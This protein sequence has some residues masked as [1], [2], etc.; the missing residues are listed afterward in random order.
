MVFLWSLPGLWEWFKTP[1]KL[2]G[3]ALVA[4]LA[5]SC[6][7]DYGTKNETI[8]QLNANNQV[9][10]IS[11][12]VNEMNVKTLEETLTKNHDMMTKTLEVQQLQEI[13]SVELA[14]FSNTLNEIN[15]QLAKVETLVDTTSSDIKQ[16]SDK[17]PLSKKT[18]AKLKTLDELTQNL[19]F[20]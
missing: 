1:I 15:N 12:T 8:A 9:L 11:N 14:V 4:Y 6:V 17:R 20:E 13:E 18:L 19:D 10:T 7:S 5:Y 3:L 16:E 2:L